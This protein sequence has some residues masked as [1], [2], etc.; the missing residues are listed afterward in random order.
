MESSIQG[1]DPKKENIHN[2]P[3]FALSRRPKFT[4]Q[5]PFRTLL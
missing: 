1:I 3:E 2:A 5:S 4:K